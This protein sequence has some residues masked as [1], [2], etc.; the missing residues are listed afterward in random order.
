MRIIFYCAD[1]DNINFIDDGGVTKLGELSID[2]GRPFQSVEDKT[3][4]VTLVF[5]STQITATAT[6]KEGTEI[7]NCEFKFETAG[8]AAAAK[9]NK[10]VPEEK[11]EHE[12]EE[13]ENSLDNTKNT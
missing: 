5:G 1:G 10:N 12:K 13:E 8:T 3:V 11:K 2:I 7:R 6:N 4:K 9:E